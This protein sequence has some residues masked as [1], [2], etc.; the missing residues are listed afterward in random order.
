M[1]LSISS[2]SSPSVVPVSFSDGYSVSGVIVLKVPLTSPAPS[3]G[4]TQGPTP[5]ATASPSTTATPTPAPTVTVTQTVTTTAESIKLDGEQFTGITAGLVLVLLLL[6][7][8][9]VAQ[10]KR[11]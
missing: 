3:P 4:V 5:S 10:M 2:A 9:V 1:I 8:L 7:A 6:A 11:P